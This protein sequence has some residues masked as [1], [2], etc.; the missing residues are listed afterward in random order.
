MLDAVDRIDAF[1]YVFDRVVFRIFSRLDG[2]PF[3]SHILQSRDF[4]TDLLLRQLLSADMLVL[5]MIRAV[6]TAI[7]AVV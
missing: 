1:Q 2:Q 6:F 3:V 5:S 4:P 7:D